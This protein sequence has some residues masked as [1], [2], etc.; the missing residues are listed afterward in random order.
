M[1]DK[2]I[3]P[4]T[5]I[6]FKPDFKRFGLTNLTDNM[7]ALMYKRVYDIAACTN[8]TVK[9]YLNDKLLNIKGFDK[10]VD[11]FY[12]DNENND[13]NDNNDDNNESESENNIIGFNLKKCKVFETVNDRWNV[14]VVFNPE[15][16]YEHI[17]FVNGISTYKG[18]T[19]VDY[20]INNII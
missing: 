17:S 6:S 20:V 18:G 13:N 4:Y 11:Y 8:N 7:I 5:K 2:T 3:K 19:H 1:G 9:V 14:C 16:G 15:N 10:Y 12:Q